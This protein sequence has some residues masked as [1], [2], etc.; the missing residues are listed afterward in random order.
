M[1]RITKPAIEVPKSRSEAEELLAEIGRAQRKLAEIEVGMNARLA[2]VKQDWEQKADPVN[3][4]IESSFDRLHAWAEA[5]RDTL[6]DGASKTAKLATGELSW[7]LTPPSVS[8]RGQDKII[9]ALQKLGLDEFLR[10][11]TEVNKEAILAAPDKVKSVKGITLSQHEMF[12]A[13]PFESEI[14]KAKPS[15]RAG[16]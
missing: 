16:R 4:A 2:T 7:R 14:E 1:A 3:A 6:L 12:V 11:R 10:Q 9:E 8:L 15:K 5:N 13:K